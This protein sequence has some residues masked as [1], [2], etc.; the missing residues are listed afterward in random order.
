M[1]NFHNF[2]LKPIAYNDLKLIYKWRNSKRIKS[3]MYTDHQISWEE[4]SQWFKNM[5]NNSQ[6]KAW[7]LY[8]KHQPQGLVSITNFDKENSRCYWGFYIGEKSAPKGTGTIMGI[9]ALNK[10]FNEMGLH[11]VCAEV[12]HTNTGSLGYHRKLGFVPEG[13]FVDHIW[14]D[15]QYLDVIPMALFSKN[16]EEVKAELMSK[17]GGGEL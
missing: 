1:V 6:K 8:N 12:I 15:T 7:L 10:L 2:Q 16:W 4:H 11:K 17:L 9:L 3:V 14:K 5:Q 13:R